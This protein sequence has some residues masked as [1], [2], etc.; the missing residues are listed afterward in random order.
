MQIELV[1]IVHEAV[2][3]G[4]GQSGIA[5]ELVPALDGELAG[6]RVECAS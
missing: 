5:N 1:G 2:E 6:H 3:D 4:V